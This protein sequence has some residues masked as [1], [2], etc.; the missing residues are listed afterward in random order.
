MSDNSASATNIPVLET[1]SL[2]D[3]NKK[4]NG[5]GKFFLG[6]LGALVSVAVLAAAAWGGYIW[7]GKDKFTVYSNYNVITVGNTEPNNTP[8]SILLGPTKHYA[9]FQCPAVATITTGPWVI[10]GTKYANFAAIPS[11]VFS[12]SNPANSSSGPNTIVAV[13]FQYGYIG[14]KGFSTKTFV[15]ECSSESTTSG[16]GLYACWQTFAATLPANVVPMAM[17]IAV[18]GDAANLWDLE[19]LDP[20][21]RQ[22]FFTAIDVYTPGLAMETTYAGVVTS[23]TASF[24]TNNGTEGNFYS[25]SLTPTQTTPSVSFSS[26]TNGNMF[27]LLPP[28]RNSSP[29]PGPS[30]FIDDSNERQ[31]SPM[32]MEYLTRH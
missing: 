30:Q 21:V 9:A 3:P 8:T 25:N 18:S 27:Q 4:K 29:V 20:S 1:Q 19:G 15:N 22:P 24:L 17:F 7:L 13:T 31:R 2:I 5:V 16:Q 6:L 11:S 26:V 14:W 32:G 28:S 10:D 23:A 12:W